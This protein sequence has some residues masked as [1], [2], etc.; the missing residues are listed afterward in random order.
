LARS[1]S[2]L[3]SVALHLSLE[4]AFSLAL[5]LLNRLGWLDKA[6]SV[7]RLEYHLNLCKN[8]SNKGFRSVEILSSTSGKK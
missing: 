7:L 3:S 8:Y 5:G 6:S 2:V 1:A 4:T